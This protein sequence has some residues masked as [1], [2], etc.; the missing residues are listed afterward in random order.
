MKKIFTFAAVGVLVILM[1]M[2]HMSCSS[3]SGSG[4]SE[5]ATLD[6]ANVERT[7]DYIVET[8]PGCDKGT[9][10][11]ANQV[12]L[13]AVSMMKQQVVDK[14]VM[15][16]P[17]SETLQPAAEVTEPI[18]LE[19]TCPGNEG[20]MIGELKGDDV[21]GDLSG[22]I[23]FNNFCSGEAGSSVVINGKLSFS[24]KLDPDSGELTSLKGSS[25]G[26]T[27]TVDEAG[28]QRTYSTSFNASLGMSGD[29][30]SITVKSFTFADDTEGTEIKLQNFS[31]TIT[32]GATSTSVT[33]SGAID[34]TDEGSVQ[35]QTVG[36]L[37]VSDDGDTVA[38]TIVITGA[39]NTSMQITIDD[40]M[41]NILADTD[42][43]GVLEYE[44]CLDCTG[45]AVDDITL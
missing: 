44:Q 20:T 27:I 38:G 2:A 15:M 6:K 17:L 19:G 3:D 8:V 26:I 16:S 12:I 21:T 34:V 39:D 9:V 13:D 31:M 23:S 41:L 28:E 42:G 40:G 25:K 35:F 36:P 10:V 29:T 1:S 33:M 4:S 45:V 37:T 32:E 11:T 14:R 43:D 30:I 7:L 24:G 18:E 5:P 22:D